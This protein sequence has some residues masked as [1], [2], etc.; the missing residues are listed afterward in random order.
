[1]VKM[2]KHIL[3]PYDFTEFADVAFEKAIKFAQ[4]FDANITLLTVIGSEIDT[5]GMNYSRAQ[6][7]SEKIDDKTK[8]DLN[9]I[10]ESQDIDNINVL[11][12]IIH[13]DSKVNGVLSYAEKNDV[14]LIIMGSHGRSGFKKLVLG[15]V[16]SGV[17]AKASCPVMVVKPSKHD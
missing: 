9:K 13:N 12:N 17:M 6:E 1:M 2:I 3:V 14:D 4:K 7:A 15:S 16:A 8:D 10:K 11:T 5:T